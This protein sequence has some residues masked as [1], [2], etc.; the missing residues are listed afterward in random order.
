M[1]EFRWIDAPP[2]PRAGGNAAVVAW[3]GRILLLG[4]Q[5]PSD[6]VS[7]FDPIS[8]SWRALP[9][10]PVA[11]SSHGAAVLEGRV[12]VFGGFGADGA[13]LDSVAV[14]DGSEWS[15]AGTMPIA[16][17]RFGLGVQEGWAFLIGGLRG[18][19]SLARVD[20]FHPTEGWK[21]VAD[22][23]QAAN[24]L[25]AA[26]LLVAGG[27]DAQG[28]GLAW[29]LRYDPGQDRWVDL[30]PMGT[31]RRNFA[32]TRLGENVV[33]AGG[34]NR[35]GEG[36]TEFPPS[37]E[38]FDGTKWTRLP[39]LPNPRD[40]VRGV[41]A[42]GSVWL[43]GGYDGQPRATGTRGLWRSADSAWRIDGDLRFHLAALG[44]W[45]GAPVPGLGFEPDEEPDITNIPLSGLQG[46]GFPV[47]GNPEGMTFYLKFFR[48]PEGLDPARS[49]RLV[50]EPTL[51]FQMGEG[52][53]LRRFVDGGGHVVVKKGLVQKSGYPFGLEDPYP[54]LR[55]GT[56]AEL[57][58]SVIFSSL[59]VLPEDPKGAS[60][61]GVLA[62]HRELL[63]LYRQSF[64][65]PEDLGKQWRF[66]H[67]R[68][69]KEP[70]VFANYLDLPMPQDPKRVFLSGLLLVYEDLPRPRVFEVGSVIRLPQAARR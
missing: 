66:G 58:D 18:D 57:D 5:G 70:M 7:E 40:G 61:D 63:E 47:T 25:E 48:Y 23:P 31:A 45:P 1:L 55:A 52:E 68:L 36:P 54:P 11:R 62:F 69:P 41:A 26:G 9:R 42:L 2:A 60:A 14:F 56:Q 24:R 6:E 13:T 8:G 50:L 35:V 67:L 4:G 20:S 19:E 44:D 65:P 27:Q 16:R 43:F 33:A 22:L 37:A 21:R 59:Y 46:L 51:A 3:R 64:G 53:E 10:M 28:N 17:A 32:L 49:A 38:V 39:D 30:P 15:A 29:V 34:W 12:Y